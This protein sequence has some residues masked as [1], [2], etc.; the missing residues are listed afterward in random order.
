[1]SLTLDSIKV[2][3]PVTDCARKI[4]LQLSIP[5]KWIVNSYPLW[6]YPKDRS[7]EQGEAVGYRQLH[8]N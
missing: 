4:E 3:L 2:Q 6:I 8:F 1:M 7:Y 5:D